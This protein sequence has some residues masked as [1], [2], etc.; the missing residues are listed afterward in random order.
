MDAG[1]DTGPMLLSAE[2]PIAPDDTAATLTFTLGALGA[3]L[4]VEALAEVDALVAR[5]QPDGATYA[6]KIAKAEAWLDW[7]QPSTVL[8]RRVRAFDPF[9]VAS[10][11]LNETPLKVW[12]A[13]AAGSGHDVP[14]GTVV[15]AGVEGV[16]IACGQ[17]TLRVTELQRPGARRMP[18]RE[19]LAGF[20]VAPGQRCGSPPMA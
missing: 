18:A 4:I 19:F 2:V 15:E 16:T 7:T 11:L 20:P 8:A 10:T 9:P 5:P 3:R 1:L 12:R 17:G 13:V 6:S 14:P